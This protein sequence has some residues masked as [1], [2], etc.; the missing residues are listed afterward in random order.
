M[1]WLHYEKKTRE[2]IV[3]SEVRPEWRLGRP[4]ILPQH[5]RQAWDN[6]WFVTYGPFQSERE[7]LYFSEDLAL[8]LL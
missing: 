4:M 8:E 3:T 7:A 2:M 6:G 5:G 1:W